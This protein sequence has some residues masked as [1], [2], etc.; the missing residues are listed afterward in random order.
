MSNDPPTLDKITASLVLFGQAT[1]EAVQ[2]FY[3]TIAESFASIEWKPIEFPVQDTTRPAEKE[4][5]AS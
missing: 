5:Q 1:S 2:T 3:D 4:A